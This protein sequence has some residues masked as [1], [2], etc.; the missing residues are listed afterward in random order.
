MPSDSL[1][2]IAS[3]VLLTMGAYYSSL[4]Y[5]GRNFERRIEIISR[6]LA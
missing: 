5:A 3:I 2:T 4:R 6:R 1:E